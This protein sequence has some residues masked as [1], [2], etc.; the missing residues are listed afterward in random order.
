MI[1]TGAIGAGYW[2][3]KHVSNFLECIHTGA[4]PLTDGRHGLRVVRALE[5]AQASLRDGGTMLPLGC[6]KQWLT[7]E[8]ASHRREMLEE[9]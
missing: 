4:A 5:T 9:Q 6:A 8:E 1:G 3:P 2:G 7:A